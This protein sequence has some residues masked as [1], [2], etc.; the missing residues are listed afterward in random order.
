MKDFS[1]FLDMR[2]CKNWAHKIDSWK[3]LSEE[4]FCR[5]FLEHRGPHL[6]SPPGIPFGQVLQVSSCSSS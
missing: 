5:F 1:A 6:C 2:R 4:L 3:Y